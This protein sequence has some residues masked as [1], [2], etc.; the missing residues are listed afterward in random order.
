MREE[1]LNEKSN[2][3]TSSSLSPALA[4]RIFSRNRTETVFRGIAIT[5]AS[6]RTTSRGCLQ[7]NKKVKGT[8]FSVVY[9][10]QKQ[11]QRRTRL[12]YTYILRILRISRL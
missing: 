4:F 7:W 1:K 2:E 12:Y 10:K 9:Q 8:P 11:K 5:L 3:V 6:F